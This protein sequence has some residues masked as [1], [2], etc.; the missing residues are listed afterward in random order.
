MTEPMALKRMR[1]DAGFSRKDAAEQINVSVRMLAYYEQGT[2][3]PS[4]ETVLALAQLYQESAEDV[5]FAALNSRQRDREDSRQGH[6]T[7]RK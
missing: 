3:T 1:Q 4:I 7:D 6:Q 2:R 5:I